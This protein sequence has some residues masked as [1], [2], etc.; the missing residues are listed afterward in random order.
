MKKKITFILAAFIA[1]SVGFPAFAGSW[2][3]DGSA[4]R[5]QNEDGSYAKNGWSW[6]EGRCYY[7][8]PEGYCLMNTTTP[9]GHTVDGSGA[10]VVNGVIQTQGEEPHVVSVSNLTLSLPSGYSLK[11]S[12]QAGDGVYLFQENG[13]GIISVLSKEVPGMDGVYDQVEARSQEI[14]DIAM[15]TLGAP[16][17]REMKGF[18]TGSWF[19]YAYP[20]GASMGLSGPLY[21]YIRVSNA[22]CQ[23][24]FFAGNTGVNPDEIMM[25]NLK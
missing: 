21:A 9:D 10:W 15:S 12:S 5:Y 13:E 2:Q 1:A 20:D 11:N 16:A 3:Q 8:T 19:A 17:S 23:M 22:K 14:A 6:V 24:V 25:N 4:W 18:P 7:F